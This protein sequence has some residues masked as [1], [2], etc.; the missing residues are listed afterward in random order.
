MSQ[1]GERAKVTLSLTAVAL[2][3]LEDLTSERKRGE[4]VSG[5]IVAAA[6]ARMETKQVLLP[7]EVAER[8]RELAAL[9]VM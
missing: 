3:A 1:L 9:L 7:C 6:K 5:L 2:D 4:F 8:L